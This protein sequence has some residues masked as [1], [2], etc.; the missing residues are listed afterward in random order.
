MLRRVVLVAASTVLVL[1]GG[2]AVLRSVDVRQAQS[3]E[4]RDAE[5]RD[6]EMRSIAQAPNRPNKGEMGLMRELNLSSDQMTKIQQIRTRYRDQLKSDRDSARQAQQDLRT[7]MAGNAT[8]DQI[9]DKYRQVKDLRAKVADAQFN[10]T[11]E[12]RN[13]LAPEQRQK[14]AARMEKRRGEMRDRVPNRAP[15]A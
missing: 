11:L 2:A 4:M 7:L 14:F 9:R 8:D 5:M 3:V 12:I 6:A 10:S 13:V 1:I 15:G